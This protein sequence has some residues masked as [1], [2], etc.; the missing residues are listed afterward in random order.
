[1]K[2]KIIFHECHQFS[3]EL[4]SNNEHMISRVSFDFQIGKNEF[5]DLYCDVKQLVGGS[6]VDSP[7]EVFPPNGYEGKYNYEKY[8]EEVERYYRD[9]FGPQGKGINIKAGTMKENTVSMPREVEI[10]VD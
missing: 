2:I 5:K 4:G 10:E 9:S 6:F 1:M 7:L 8:R 3:Q